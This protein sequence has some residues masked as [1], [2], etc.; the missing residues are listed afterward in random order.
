MKSPNLLLLFFLL[1]IIKCQDD[2]PKA[3]FSSSSVASVGVES[4]HEKAVINWTHL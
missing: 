3:N 1:I 2:L 4:S